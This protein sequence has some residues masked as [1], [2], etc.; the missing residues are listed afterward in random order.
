MLIKRW[1]NLGVRAENCSSHAKSE[2]GTQMDSEKAGWG[3]RRPGRGRERER[4]SA[5]NEKDVADRNVVLLLA[6]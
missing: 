2:Y 3:K 4:E 1:S 5:G 6:C